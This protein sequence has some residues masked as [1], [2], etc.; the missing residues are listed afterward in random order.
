MPMLV[1]L[2]KPSVE[3][4]SCLVYPQCLGA[5]SEDYSQRIPRLFLAQNGRRITILLSMILYASR[6]LLCPYAIA[7]N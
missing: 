6:V 5:L 1:L 7:S 2:A 3:V 4:M